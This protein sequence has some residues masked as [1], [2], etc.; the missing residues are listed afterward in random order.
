MFKQLSL[1]KISLGDY[2]PRH[3][4][5]IPPG[6]YFPSYISETASITETEYCSRAQPLTVLRQPTL[7]CLTITW[8]ETPTTIGMEDEE[9]YH[10]M[11]HDLERFERIHHHPEF[12]PPS[13]QYQDTAKATRTTTVMQKHAN[14]PWLSGLRVAAGG[15]V[16]ASVGVLVGC[17]VEGRRTMSTP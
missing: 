15:A 16:R 8:L 4:I 7:P 14:S 2:P 5:D 1:T 9:Y 10:T 11:L 13:W 17:N 3:K 6:S 12:L